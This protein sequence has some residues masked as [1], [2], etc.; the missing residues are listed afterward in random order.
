[1]PS[2][3]QLITWVNQ[4]SKNRSEAPSGPVARAAR[5]DGEPRNTSLTS[6]APESFCMAS[7]SFTVLP[8]AARESAH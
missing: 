6:A 7:R 1:M 4:L 5:P 8:V 3:F 2:A